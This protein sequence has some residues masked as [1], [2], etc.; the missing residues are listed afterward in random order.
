[1]LIKINTGQQQA[2]P[3]TE[4]RANPTNY[5]DGLSLSAVRPSLVQTRAKWYHLGIE[6]DIPLDTLKVRNRMYPY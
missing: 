6:L 4:Q 2:T 3:S 1:M 5:I